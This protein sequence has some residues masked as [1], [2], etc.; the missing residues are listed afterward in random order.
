MEK[1]QG[2]QGA[3]DES[4]V[5]SDAYDRTIYLTDEEEGQAR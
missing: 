4:E 3:I 5:S 1:N 2:Y